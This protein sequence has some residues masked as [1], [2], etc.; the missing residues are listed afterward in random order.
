MANSPD[1]FKLTGGARIGRANATWPFATLTVT[2][3]RL[4]L[5]VSLIGSY[6]FTADQIISIE[7]YG[8][9]P[10]LG[11]GIKISHRVP[12]YKQKMIFWSWNDPK[13]VIRNINRTGFGSSSP[14]ATLKE[15]RIQVAEKQ[16]QGG[17]AIRTS[18]AIS[19]VVLWNL[20]FLYDF[21]RIF[22]NTGNRVRFG[23]TTFMALGLVLI[24]SLLTLISTDFR[25]LILK[26]GREIGEINKFLYFL[27]FIC[28]MMLFMLYT[29]Q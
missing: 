25:R 13:E 24:V 11:R 2:R 18:A 26:E 17:F 29:A 4:D 21:V 16:R 15:T 20:L 23:I 3:D 12:N 14:S 19:I 1:Q 9:I 27:I 28:G 22:K 7:P 8:L 10:L 6:S 5:N